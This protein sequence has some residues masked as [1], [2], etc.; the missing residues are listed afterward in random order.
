MPLLHFESLIEAIDEAD[1]SKRL[2]L[3]P[4]LDRE[5]IGP[6]SIDVRLGTSFRLL[7]R[8]VNAGLDPGKHS[9]AVVESSQ[10]RIAVGIGENLWLH[11]G[12][13][14]LGA[15]LEYLR[16][17]LHLGGY[18][19]GRSSWG[20]VGLVVATAIMVQPGFAGSLTLE[21]VNHGESPIAL[22][23]GCRIAQITVHT[24][25]GET[26]HAYIGKY[27]GPTGPEVSRLSRE[28]DEI[29]ELK[30]VAA[31]LAGVHS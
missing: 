18:V 4:L 22:Y 5:Q 1:E 24:L 26:G 3:M 20:R 14:I 7:R 25:P 12:Q 31:R 13:F 21:L 6:A 17:P 16:F 23:P 8:T 27:A 30:T 28:R 29:N 10:E 19:I 11:P 2:V 15:T 9:E